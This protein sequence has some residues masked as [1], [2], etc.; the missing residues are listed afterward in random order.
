MGQS[1]QE[2]TK[3]IL[4]K[5]AFKKFQGIWSALKFF[6]GILPQNLLSLLLNTLSQMC[7]YL[8]NSFYCNFDELTL[9]IL[10]NTSQY[11]KQQKGDTFQILSQVLIRFLREAILSY[12]PA[13]HSLELENK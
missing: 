2:W 8:I 5:T 12:T 13:I 6:K 1:I 10:C 11:R 9:K 3:Q 7:Q 4:W